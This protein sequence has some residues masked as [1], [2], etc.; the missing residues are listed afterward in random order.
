MR[1][2][3]HR[4]RVFQIARTEPE[5]AGEAVHAE[6]I[7]CRFPFCE[8]PSR[9]RGVLLVTPASTTVVSR[10]MEAKEFEKMRSIRG[11]ELL[12]EGMPI[13]IIEQGLG[14]ASRA[15][16]YN[17]HLPTLV[18]TRRM[19]GQIPRPTRIIDLFLSFHDNSH[20]DLCNFPLWR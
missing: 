13:L 1:Q 5:S 11:V 18:A 19:C 12:Y 6:R 4:G 15:A 16:E 17:F 8:N 3:V 7:K 14:L 9:I 2:N 10:P 20:Y